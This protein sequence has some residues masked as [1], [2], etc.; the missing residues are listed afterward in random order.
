MLTRDQIE[1]A[2][3]LWINPQAPGHSIDTL[4]QF[5]I[6]RQGLDDLLE[7]K[8]EL[9]DYLELVASVGVPIDDYLEVTTE[10]LLIIGGGHG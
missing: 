2:F 3:E 7:G 10:N 5:A 9:S 1:S 8:I 4:T 6:A